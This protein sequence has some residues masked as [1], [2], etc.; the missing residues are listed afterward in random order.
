[1]FAILFWVDQ[2][3]QWLIKIVDSWPV[4]NWAWD[5][6]TT[7]KQVDLVVFQSLSRVQLFGTSWTAACQA[8]LSFTISRTLLH[9]TKI[10]SVWHLDIANKMLKNIWKRDRKPSL[11]KACLKLQMRRPKDAFTWYKGA[12]RISKRVPSWTEDEGIWQ[13]PGPNE[14]ASNSNTRTGDA[15]P[16]Q[17]HHGAC[18]LQIPLALCHP[19]SKLETSRGSQ[20]FHV[21]Q[22]CTVS[23]SHGRTLPRW[24]CTTWREGGSYLPRDTS[25][26]PLHI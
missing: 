11:F 16:S 24:V 1:M 20:G 6:K 9:S 18:L 5:F 12:K 8:S 14:T 7:F 15:S 17:P 19:L 13:S 25:C 21:T 4:T 22:P 10:P 26:L 3:K 23:V 2:C